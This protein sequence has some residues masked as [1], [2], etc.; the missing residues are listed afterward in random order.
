MAK[1]NDYRQ[2]F[3]L[4]LISDEQLEQVQKLAANANEDSPSVSDIISGW[5]NKI[6]GDNPMAKQAVEEAK[7]SAA[8]NFAKMLSTPLYDLTSD[9]GDDDDSGFDKIVQAA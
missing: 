9:D 4:D 6:I 8:D 5:I 7:A 2:T 1:R 3:L